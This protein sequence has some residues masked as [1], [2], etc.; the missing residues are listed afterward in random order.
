MRRLLTGLLLLCTALTIG[1]AGPIAAPARADT[2]SPS[3]APLN[4]PGPQL[5]VP[6]ATLNAALSCHGNPKAGPQPILLSPATSV[7]PVENYSWNW[8]KI[9]A[10]QGRY[11]CLVT[12][13]FH[14]VGDIQV[15]AEYHVNA[16]RTMYQRTGRKIAILGHSQGG[17]NP[18]WALR[19]WP[20]VRAK[21]AEV[22]GMAPSNHGTVVLAGCVVG[23]TTCAPAIWQ[24]RAGSEFMKALN[25]GAETFAG[26]D[27]TSIYTKLDEVVVPPPSSGLTTGAGN[28]ANVAVQD[29]CKGDPY[30]HVLMGTVSP[31]VYA[32]VTDAL[33]NA[34]PAK[35]TRI[36]RSWCSKLFMPGINPLDLL[37]FAPVLSALP[38]LLLTVAPNVTLTGAPMLPK[39]PALRCYVY[40]AGC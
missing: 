24:Q 9:F 26:I 10:Q 4:R 16:I 35:L 37:S 18:R 25:S 36:D 19:F 30:E 17:M 13:P 27:Y 31:A 40:A 7:T 5:S 22:I 2:T 33:N 1:L 11:H 20:D 14:T 15:A 21:V 3:Y 34:G 6:A 12:M 29:V 8:A 39:E 38:N 32:A 23:L 28:K